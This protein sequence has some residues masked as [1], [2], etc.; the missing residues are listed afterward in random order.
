MNTK[1]YENTSRVKKDVESLIRTFPSLKS[2][3]CIDYS[4]GGKS[5]IQITG[6]IPV[7]FKNVVYN[8]PISLNIPFNY[9]NSPPSAFVSP[10]PNMVIRPSSHVDHSGKFYHAKISLWDKKILENNLV[11]VVTTMQTIFSAEPPL[12]SKPAVQSPA[13]FTPQYI[14]GGGITPFANNNNPGISRP[15]GNNPGYPLNNPQPNWNSSHQNYSTSAIYGTNNM[16]SSSFEQQ[17]PA[18]LDSRPYAGIPTSL[19]TINH[20]QLPVPISLNSS[21]DQQQV[22]T[23]SL[24]SALL[25]KITKSTTLIVSQKNSEMDMLVGLNQEI[26]Q[27]HDAILN[28]LARIWDENE[29]NKYKIVHVREKISSLETLL[30]SL[31]SI[32]R[33]NP[34]DI[35]QFRTIYRQML[36]LLAEDSAI[37]D[38]IYYL[39]KALNSGELELSLFLKHVR[40]LAR[41]QFLKRA[42]FEKIVKHVSTA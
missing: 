6:T 5:F 22:M 18:Y 12:F 1:D 3:N 7:N 28:G 14:H 41:E 20:Q 10:T 35:L 37:E 4:G 29:A 32:A 23:I 19:P 39:G 26:Q 21:F 30:K 34:D 38:T 11:S 36:D 40:S 15:Y 42:L 33:V 8:I 2:K 13:Q 31:E 27:S 9:P 16:K 24:R 17:T 25:E